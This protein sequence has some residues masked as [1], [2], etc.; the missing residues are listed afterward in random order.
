M[1][2][3][4][5]LRYQTFNDSPPN[6]TLAINIHN[7][8]I[9]SL[10]MMVGFGLFGT[11]GIAHFAPRVPRYISQVFERTRVADPRS[12][13][14]NSGG[15]RSGESHG[16]CRMRVGLLGRRRLSGRRAFS[17]GFIF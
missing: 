6:T 10:A 7:L 13:A 9:S 1:S 12:E 2:N 5:P 17:G 3:A 11:D 15:R 16:D 14:G 4:C 8:H